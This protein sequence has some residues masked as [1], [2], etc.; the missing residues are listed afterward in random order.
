LYDVDLGAVVIDLTDL[1][2][3]GEEVEIDA[4]IDAGNLEI[5][6][7]HDVGI[8]GSASVDIGRVS[9]PNRTTA[10]VGDPHLD[11]DEPGDRGTVVLDAHV[12]LGNIDIRR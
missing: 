6:L 3:D 1:P 2:W 4:D 12:S 8:V 10:G 7:P 9:G 11:W 5:F